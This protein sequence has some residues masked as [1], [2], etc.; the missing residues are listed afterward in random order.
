MFENVKY[1]LMNNIINNKNKLIVSIFYLFWLSLI[2]S[3]NTKPDE[4]SLIGQGFIQTINSLRL[5]IPLI[6]S[7]IFIILTFFLILKTKK[8]TEHPFYFF[9]L[10][11]AY[12]F[13][14][15][16]A[17]IMQLDILI[18]DEKNIFYSFLG[19]GTTCLFILVN[20]F[21]I[22]IENF[23][24]ILLATIALVSF[25]LL[26]I[27]LIQNGIKEN[28]IL[29]QIID[30]N[31][32]IFN[33]PLQRITGLTRILSILNIYLILIFL[34]K[35]KHK[36]FYFILI[37]IIS[38]IIFLA[39][40]RGTVVCYFLCIV[41]L[42]FFLI[43][44]NFRDKVLLI[45]ILI[46][47]PFFIYLLTKFYNKPFSKVN[48]NS[49][50]TL[51]I[52]EKNSDI[53]ERSKNTRYLINHT[54]GRLEIWKE[55]LKKYNYKNIIGYGPQADRKLLKT[56]NP[57]SDKYGN[58]ASN[59]FIYAFICGGYLGLFF[60]ALINYKIIKATID[61]VIIKKMKNIFFY[62]LSL[63]YLVYFLVRQIF[64]NSFSLFSIDFLLVMASFSISYYFKKNYKESI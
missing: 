32:F 35:P 16:L 41:Y 11:L 22:K 14:Q 55:L 3:I 60:F 2:L 52:L 23:L 6:I 57:L 59:A 51:N 24:K 39:E 48:T 62:K 8:K 53:L 44:K 58:N 10:W 20:Y 21:K 56:G 28:F 47:F 45:V 17:E 18:A 5:I 64:E 46:M 61:L 13:I 26:I 7:I 4:L 30:P 54:S 31:F 33:Q 37:T 9:Y 36:I 19:L 15:I 34:L 38:T 43:K 1:I 50:Y 25:T 27:Y 12:F 29:H 40:A 49:E 63:L 42:I